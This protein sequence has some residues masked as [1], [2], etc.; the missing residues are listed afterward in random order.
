MQVVI[1]AGGLGSRLSEETKIVP[2]ALV[3][4][5]KKP[6]IIHLM[7]YYQ[8]YGYNDF[9]ICL[10]YKGNLINEFFLKEKHK[11]YFKRT[12][13]K[14]INTGKKSYTG[15][16][17]KRIK[18]YIYGDFF[19]TYCDGLSNINLNKTLKLFKKSKKIGLV[20]TI[21]P[22][23]RFGVL[24][25]DKKNN[26]LNFDEKSKSSYTWINAGFFIFQNFIKRNFIF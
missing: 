6:I 2:K 13:I 1:L 4:I 9:I 10:G 25:I 22:R 12:K 18:K 15:E 24:S 3:K 7:N 23:S 26:V 14:L 5:G 16:R 21:N 8:S 11:N 20:S 17:I 19:L